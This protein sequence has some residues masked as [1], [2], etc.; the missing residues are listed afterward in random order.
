MHACTTVAGVHMT[1]LP[2]M[3]YLNYDGT[4]DFDGLVSSAQ[5]VNSS[6]MLS[7]S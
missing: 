1:H 5:V 3:N 4:I 6:S 7:D 2:G